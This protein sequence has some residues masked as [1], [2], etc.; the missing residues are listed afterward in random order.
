MG[1]TFTIKGI[2]ENS[3][4][5]RPRLN[6]EEKRLSEMS[7]RTASETRKMKTA[8]LKRVQTGLFVVVVVN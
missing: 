1:K 6:G 5:K 4:R 2:N 3:Q 8:A 7:P